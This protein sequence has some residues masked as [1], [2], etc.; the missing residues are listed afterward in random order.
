LFPYLT[1]RGVPIESLENHSRRSDLLLGNFRIE[2]KKTVEEYKRRGV[3]Q[4]VW[5]STDWLEVKPKD[6]YRNELAR[7]I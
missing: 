3:K 5:V 4:C 2:K 7:I 6:R 1:V